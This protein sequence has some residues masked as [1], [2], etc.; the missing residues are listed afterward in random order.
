MSTEALRSAYFS[1]CPDVA[2]PADVARVQRGYGKFAQ[3]MVKTPD[4]VETGSRHVLF[5]GASWPHY[6][7]FIMDAMSRLWALPATDPA[8]P[9]LFIDRASL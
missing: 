9:L 3:D 7:Y 8:L 6:G 1:R 4:K 5:V 2:S